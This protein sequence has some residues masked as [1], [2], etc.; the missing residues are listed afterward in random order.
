MR[1]QPAQRKRAEQVSAGSKTLGVREIYFRDVPLFGWKFSF[2]GAS[3]MSKSGGTGGSTSI[4]GA[5]K[6]G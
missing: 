1:Y 2:T 3:H 5:L 6:Q 4:L